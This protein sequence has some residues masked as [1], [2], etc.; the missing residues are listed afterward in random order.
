MAYQLEHWVDWVEFI[1]NETAPN[2][3]WQKQPRPPTPPSLK[4]CCFDFF[5]SEYKHLQS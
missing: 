1:Y 4:P 5:F 2:R 3:L